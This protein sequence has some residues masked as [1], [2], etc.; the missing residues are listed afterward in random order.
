[1]QRNAKSSGSA[2]NQASVSEIL[3][4]AC[5]RAVCKE[6]VRHGFETRPGVENTSESTA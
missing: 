2:I 3:G 5:P 1:M 4:A 6:T